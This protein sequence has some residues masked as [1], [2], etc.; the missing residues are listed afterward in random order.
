MSER[1]GLGQMQA[2]AL[3]I[4]S[5]ARVANVDGPGTYQVE[6]LGPKGRKVAS[7]IVANALS[8]ANVMDIVRT[9][10]TFKITAI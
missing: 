10:F 7:L 1:G 3:A 4:G 6:V 2:E 9:Q 8:Q 5:R